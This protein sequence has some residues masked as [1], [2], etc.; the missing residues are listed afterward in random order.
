MFFEGYRS[1]TRQLG[2]GDFFFVREH[3]LEEEE[4]ADKLLSAALDDLPPQ[5]RLNKNLEDHPN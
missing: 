5:V 3:E 1:D 4:N 2:I